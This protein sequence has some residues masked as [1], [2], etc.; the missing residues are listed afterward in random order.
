GM[1]IIGF[2]RG[3]YC[4]QPGT[5]RSAPDTKPCQQ[6]IDI[7]SV[8]KGILL[9]WSSVADQVAAAYR[10]HLFGNATLQ[11]LPADTEGPRFVLNSTNMQTKVLWRFSKPFMGDYRVG[12]IRNPNLELAVAGYRKNQ[13]CPI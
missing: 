7:G 1:E 4:D 3:G 11:D 5:A 10:K 6:T 9:P 2:R 13:S 8:L 12:S